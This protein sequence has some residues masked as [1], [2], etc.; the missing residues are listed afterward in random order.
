MKQKY[1]VL[2]RN[3]STPLALGKPESLSIHL[4]KLGS[5]VKF[6]ES[7]GHETLICVDIPSGIGFRKF[8]RGHEGLRVLIRNEPSVVCPANFDPK[9]VSLFD[10]VID[11]GRPSRGG[12]FSLHW[13]QTWPKLPPQQTGNRDPNRVAIIN[14][15]KYSFIRGQLYGLRAAV[16]ATNPSVD[17]YGFGWD[18][19]LTAKISM[20]L[21]ELLLALFSGKMPTFSNVSFM[22]RRPLNFLGSTDDKLLTLSRYRASVV[23]ENESNFLS[24]KLFDCFFSRTIPIYVGSEAE[25]FGIPQELY[26]RA[27]GTVEQ[28]K[29]AMDRALRLDYSTWLQALEDWLSRE[30]LAA[31]WSAEN[32]LHRIAELSLAPRTPSEV[33]R[34]SGVLRR[35]SRRD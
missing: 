24:E 27:G 29:E 9:V 10:R 8:L 23:I 3:P 28:V 16:A 12:S 22:L 5:P 1:F 26:V 18:S 11:V 19:P 14:A 4:E 13:P 33:P 15:C 2:G 7:S 17:V 20:L 21:K 6:E 31:T 30:D 32:A 25:S 34:M 35:N